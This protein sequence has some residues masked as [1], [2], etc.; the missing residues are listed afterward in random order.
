M[1]ERNLEQQST[2]S[3]PANQQDSGGS[4]QAATQS[5]RDG[6]S[7][8]QYLGTLS[9]QEKMLTP[10]GMYAAAVA[11]SMNRPV[12]SVKAVAYRLGLQSQADEYELA[13]K[14]PNGYMSPQQYI[15]EKAAGFARSFV[16]A[17]RE[18]RGEVPPQIEAFALAEAQRQAARGDDV[19]GVLAGTLKTNNKG[20]NFLAKELRGMVAMHSPGGE[21]AS[22]G[23]RTASEDAQARKEYGRDAEFRLTP[24]GKQN[25]EALRVSELWSAQDENYAPATPFAQ[26]QRG[27]AP[28]LA[29]PYNAITG[30]AT[31]AAQNP[32]S[33][34]L[35]PASA[36]SGNS[37]RNVG[38]PWDEMA[39]ISRP[40]GKLEY[41]AHMYGRSA[42]SDNNVYDPEGRARYA[43]YDMS[44]SPV[45]LVTATNENQ[46]FPFAWWKQNVGFP[47]AEVA[48]YIGNREAGGDSNYGRNIA[49][50]RRA[51][52]R[53]TPVVP[54]G[55]DPNAVRR[56]GDKLTHA[57]H[58]QTGYASAVLGPKVAD[59]AN[60][61]GIP[62]HRMYLS[63]AAQTFVETPTEMFGDLGNALMS[64]ALPVTGG[65]I[66]AAKGGMAGGLKAAAKMG[67]VAA[68]RSAAATAGRFIDDVTEEQIE[69][70]ALNTAVQGFGDYFAPEK[71][72]M[73]MGNRDPNSKG[74]DEAV[75]AESAK[76]RGAQMEAAQEY[77]KA[78]GRKPV[79]F[80]TKPVKSFLP[81]MLLGR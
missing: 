56:A 25:H 73:L 70:G 17:Y 9:D 51:V 13:R 45:G 49:E 6:M 31:Y 30:A 39:M 48:N 66:G 4:P 26:L 68:S 3:R 53:I 24:E 27:L 22:F 12:I 64:V 33:T 19:A 61:V 14:Y 60:A 36:F 37:N 69:G 8:S 28:I 55:V 75:H 35:N 76:Q 71:T 54:D 81:Y 72:N 18:K 46:S 40:D 16:D 79:P 23:H 38:E 65:L 74:F 59:A 47:F 29:Y 57:T 50:L 67:G 44:G 34:F 80:D 42:T 20:I 7:L 43:R 52:N 21:F 62:A 63:P 5:R 77:G 58:A 78:I 2:T 10:K 32:V 11:D 1:S 15:E 41:A